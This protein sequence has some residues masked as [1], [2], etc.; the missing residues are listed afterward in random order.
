MDLLAGSIAGAKLLQTQ[1]VCALK[2]VQRI[3]QEEDKEPAGNRTRTFEVMVQGMATSSFKNKLYISVNYEEVH[4]YS[5]NGNSPQ[6]RQTSSDINI[7]TDRALR[8]CFYLSA[9]P[10]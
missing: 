1:A 4:S 5:L 8:C 10:G 9:Y 2:E 7:E 3:N 6:R